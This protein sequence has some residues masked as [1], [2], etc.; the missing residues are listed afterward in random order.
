MLTFRKALASD[1]ADVWQILKSVI[2]GG[3]TYAFLPNSTK[4]EMLNYWFS[5]EKQTYVAVLDDAIVGTF[6]MRANQLGLGAHIA[7][8][9]YMI[10]PNHAGKGIG[11]Q[12]GAFSLQEA[13]ELGYR[14]MQ[15]NLVIKTNAVAVRLWQRL[16]FQ[17]IGEIPE[18]FQHQTLGF[19]N[20]YI[21]YQKLE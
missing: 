7:N 3:D 10:A 5:S 21:M 12:M 20:A 13:R 16:G 1:K 19:V 4:K 15:F 6:V 18:A 2:A 8:A 17:I 14:A 9:S 11:Y